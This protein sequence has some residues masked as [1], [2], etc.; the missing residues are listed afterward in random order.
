MPDNKSDRPSLGAEPGE[1]RALR[2]RLEREFGRTGPPVPA[3]GG[4]GP[5][6]ADAGG[7]ADGADA[8]ASRQQA[9]AGA[10]TAP[11]GDESR[12][13]AGGDPAEDAKTGRAG[14][15]P[16]PIAP[17]LHPAVMASS[18]IIN[19]L[20]L[21]LPLVILQ[22]YDRILPNKATDT[23]AL[24]ILGLGVVVI[25]EMFMKIA[26][27]HLVGWAATRAHHRAAVDA[28]A[29]I[30]YAPPDRVEKD[31]PSVN[32]DRLNALDA[33]RDYHGGPSRL[34][35]IDLPF[36]VIFLGL[37][38]VVGG[39]LVLVPIVLFAGLATLTVLSA[40]SLKR[41]LEERAENDD[42][43]IDFIVEALTGIRTIKSLAMEPQIQRRFERL[44]KNTAEATY[45]TIVL[46]NA[47]QAYGNLLANLTM[48]SVVT[49]GGLMVING[50]LTVGTL[51]ACTLLA[52]RSMQPVLRGLGLWTQMQ[53]LSVSNARVEAL[54]ELPKAQGWG[55]IEEVA[56]RGD[57]DI[58][59]LAFRYRD[60]EEQLFSRINLT[61]AAGEIVA[62]TG[63]DNCGKSTLLKLISGEL[64]PVSGQILIDGKPLPATASIHPS[65]AYVAANSAV[66]RGTI[67]ENI[68][69]FRTG[70]TI[71]AAVEAARLI[72]LEADIHRLPDGYDT[73]LNE[74]IASEIPGGMMQR[75]GVARALAYRPRILLFDEANMALDARSDRLLREGMDRL[76]GSLTIIL[77]SSRPSFLKVAGRVFV[78]RDG[79]LHRDAVAPSGN[80]AAGA[81]SRDGD[82]AIAS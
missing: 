66:F 63:K 25:V 43:K 52:G 11:G 79:R 53:S 45:Q 19:L 69:M 13:S 62:F 58:R 14:K 82:S 23:L 44:Q 51:A 2:E 30:L 1:A 74:G 67:L 20:A 50:A 22:V 37:I 48:I 47:A 17:K 24:L 8:P 6:A 42:K 31:A 72:G 3:C 38:A 75:I 35:L 70:E 68:T 71:D 34:L 10:L 33:L 7:D 81:P 78:L 28:V 73:M 46:G 16:L 18:L 32:I 15:K 26:R 21:A 59:D 49:V 5:C 56:V 77:V 40:R 12:D 65:M 27:A 76:R 9:P 57:I 4:D 41:V 55:E 61:V 54:F 36:V 60:A 64:R 80:P 39:A 29:R